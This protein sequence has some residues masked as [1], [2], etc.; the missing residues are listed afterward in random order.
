ML[1]QTGI[2]IK[3]E[4]GAVWVETQRS[5]ACGHCATRGSCGVGALAQTMGNRPNR[6]RVAS[7][8]AVRPGDEVV[9]GL[10]EQALLQGSVTLYLLPLLAMFASTGLVTLAWPGPSAPEWAVVL[11]SLI[12][13]GAGLLAAR[14][15]AAKQL[16]HAESQPIILRTTQSHS[17]ACL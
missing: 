8:L 3:T 17:G 7:S 11:A 15:L 2:V 12:G 4:P 5:A 10:Q 14:Q 1:E 9:I 13:L 16:T 6:L